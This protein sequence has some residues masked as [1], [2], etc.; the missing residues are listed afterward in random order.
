MKS[1]S[2]SLASA[3]RPRPTS[4]RPAATARAISGWECSSGPAQ[5]LGDDSGKMLFAWL[6]L[7]A[8]SSAAKDVEILVL[9]HEV[10]VLRRQI[11]RPGWPERAVLAASP[12]SCPASRAAT[13]S[14]L[15]APC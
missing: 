15:P 10:A 2:R 8:R 14:S 1:R 3:R 7:L 9:R 11:T 4:A 13:G 5:V 6:V 12:G